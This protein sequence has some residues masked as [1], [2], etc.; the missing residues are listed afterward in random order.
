MG[1]VNVRMCEGM[2]GCVGGIE[3]GAGEGRRV[4]VRCKRSQMRIEGKGR[5]EGKQRQS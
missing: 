3:K 4:G 1:G 5:E 2:C